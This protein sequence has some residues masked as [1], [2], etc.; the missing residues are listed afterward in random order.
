MHSPHSLFKL[1]NC[2]CVECFLL[3]KETYT[4][5][6]VLYLKVLTL[7]FALHWLVFIVISVIELHEEVCEILKFVYI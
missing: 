1:F 3:P 4:F 2:V 7:T 6:I 5:I